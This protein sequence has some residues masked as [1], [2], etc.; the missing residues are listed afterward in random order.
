MEHAKDW[1]SMRQICFVILWTVLFTLINID[2]RKVIKQI[3]PSRFSFIRKDCT[4]ASDAKQNESMS[5]LTPVHA[6]KRKCK[7]IL[8]I[9]YTIYSQTT[10]K[11]TSTYLWKYTCLQ[12]RLLCVRNVNWSVAETHHMTLF[13]TQTILFFAARDFRHCTF[14]PPWESSNTY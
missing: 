13:I 8:V 9:S 7:I 4:S 10:F 14:I 12:S 6:R 3:F 5:M 2:F 1:R 11:L